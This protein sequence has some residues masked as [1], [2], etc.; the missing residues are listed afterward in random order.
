MPSTFLKTFG[1]GVLAALA[2]ALILPGLI[3]GCK[4][5]ESSSDIPPVVVVPPVQLPSDMLFY[6]TRSDQTALF[7]KQNTS[8]V[9]T[10]GSPTYPVIDVDTTQTFQSIDGFG[11]TLTGG[12]ASLINSLPANQK[13]DLLKNLFLW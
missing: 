9:F 1:S 8:L 13:D 3:T 11:Y 2:G 10:N 7:Q 12:S 4:K 6:L 5:K